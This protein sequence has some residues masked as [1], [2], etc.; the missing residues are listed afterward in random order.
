M[1]SGLIKP[2]FYLF[3]YEIKTEGI[4]VTSVDPLACG[5]F[6]QQ[7]RNRDVAASLTFSIRLLATF[8]IIWGSMVD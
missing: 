3:S 8:L 4:R 6:G 1:I 5:R 2:I 7:P